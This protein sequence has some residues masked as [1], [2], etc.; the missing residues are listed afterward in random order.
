VSSAFANMNAESATYQINETSNYHESLD[1]YDYVHFTSP[2][3]RICDA[4]IHWCLTYNIN[5]NYLVNTYGLDIN[6]IN[7]LDTNTK[8]FHREINM[9]EKINKL[10]LKQN[11]T[12]E[13]DGWVYSNTTNC[14]I[15]YFK[16]L[17]FIRVK[18]WDFKFSYLEEKINKNIGDKIKFQV[19]LKPGF[20][21]KEKI[22]IVRLSNYL[23]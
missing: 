16:E 15:I 11:Q 22:L 18:M 17:G 10:E 9:L 23:I 21:P 1:I 8:K 6:H 14:W 12:I 2:I 19:S 5:F 13:L 7:K 3:R 4:L 20:L